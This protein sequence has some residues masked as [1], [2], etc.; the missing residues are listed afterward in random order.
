M[1]FPG[2]RTVFLIGVFFILKDGP[3]AVLLHGEEGAMSAGG[4]LQKT[5]SLGVQQWTVI[6]GWG[7]C[8]QSISEIWTSV[9]HHWK[10]DT[11][12]RWPGLHSHRGSTLSCPKWA[13]SYFFFHFEKCVRILRKRIF[14]TRFTYIQLIKI[15]GK[16]NNS[17]VL[18]RVFVAQ[19]LHVLLT[20]WRLTITLWGTDPIFQL[21]RL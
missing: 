18:L 19:A 14:L 3:A 16:K 11:S 17:L 8:S 1:A 7:S 20:H 15:N 12:L 21:R 2:K 10:P 5:R 4:A 9:H 13:H 6:S